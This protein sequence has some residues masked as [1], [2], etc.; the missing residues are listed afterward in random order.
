MTRVPS[1]GVAGER[2]GQAP[3][4]PPYI[5]PLG[6]LGLDLALS[7]PPPRVLGLLLLKRRSLP[8]LPHH[9]LEGGVALI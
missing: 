4:P 8:S 6:V 5:P 1:E 9:A 3:R 7:L 2:T